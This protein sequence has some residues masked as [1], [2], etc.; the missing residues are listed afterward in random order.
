MQR[1]KFDLPKMPLNVWGYKC[2]EH[3]KFMHYPEEIIVVVID[4]FMPIMFLNH[5]LE[6]EPEVLHHLIF[7]V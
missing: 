1:F 6:T 3:L 2:L 7:I 5:M 4:V